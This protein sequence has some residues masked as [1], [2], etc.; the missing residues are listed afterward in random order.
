MTPVVSF[1]VSI[2]IGAFSGWLAGKIMK[3]GGYGFLINCLLGILG[4][5]LGG[6]LLRIL[7]VNL[8][9]TVGQILTSV[10]GAALII[11]LA[12]LLRK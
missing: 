2:L 12:S 1:I 10:I 5:L 8:G 4:G 6:W 3:G 7:G 9:G 11:W